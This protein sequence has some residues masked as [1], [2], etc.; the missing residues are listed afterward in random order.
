MKSNKNFLH[1]E[2]NYFCQLFNHNKK[3]Y[4]QHPF[5]KKSYIHYFRSEIFKFFFFSKPKHIDHIKHF[6]YEFC[7]KNKFSF[8]LFANEDGTDI[9]DVTQQTQIR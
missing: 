2:I 3:F 5:C 9:V 4:F 6:M 7:A 8:L 1:L